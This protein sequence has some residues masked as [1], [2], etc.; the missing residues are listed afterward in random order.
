MPATAAPFPHLDAIQGLYD[1]ASGR[2]SAG[3]AEPFGSSLFPG[4]FVTAGSLMWPGERASHIVYE[5][6][7]WT[8]DVPHDV[9]SVARVVRLPHLPLVPAELRGRSLVVVEVAIPRE[10]WIAAGRLAALRRLEPEIDTVAVRGPESIHPLH[11]A[12]EVPAPALGDHVCLESLP[13]AAIDAFLAVVGPGSGSNLLTASL[14]HLGPA[15]GV[16]AAGVAT[17]PDEA[18]RL[19]VRLNL[20]T[21]RLAPYTIGR[22]AVDDIVRAAGRTSAGLRRGEG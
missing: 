19:D 4:P 14:R 5:W 9:T 17:D 13:T 1:R 7:R 18:G 12:V 20:L 16:A 10:P 6:A 22:P 3:S 8:R 15:Y 11:T 21:G 2:P